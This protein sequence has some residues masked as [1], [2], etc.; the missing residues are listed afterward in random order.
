[1]RPRIM[2][3][4]AVLALGLT[5]LLAGTAA[6]AVTTQ[7]GRQEV[8]VFHFENPNLG[9]AH[10]VVQGEEVTSG[11][12]D[13]EILRGADRITKIAHVRRVQVDRVTLQQRVGSVWQN[14]IA[15]TAA[16]NSGTGSG[17]LSKTPFVKLCASGEQR[18]RVRADL[19]ARWEDNFVSRFTRFSGEFTTLPNVRTLGSACL[20]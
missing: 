11:V 12:A 10:N 6:A 4:T 2:L 8:E 1:M 18:Y 3:P 9:W 16:V 13:D 7:L 15:T 5:V 14:V 20:A 17:A 19:S